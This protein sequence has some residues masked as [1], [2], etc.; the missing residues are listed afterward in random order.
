LPIPS[1]RPHCRKIS[2]SS[3]LLKIL[4]GICVAALAM[5]AFCLTCCIA[6]IPYVGSVILLPLSVFLQAYPLYFLQQFGP[7]WQ[8]IPVSPPKP[9]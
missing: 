4:I 3:F 8:V 9:I 1:A 7:D 2:L 5:A 6:A